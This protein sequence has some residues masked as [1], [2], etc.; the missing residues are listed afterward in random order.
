MEFQENNNAST[1]NN[2]TMGPMNTS[3]II[4]IKR[5]NV[6][7]TDIKSKRPLK[8]IPMKNIKISPY[9]TNWSNNKGQQPVN[10]PHQH[11]QQQNPVNLNQNFQMMNNSIGNGDQQSSFGNENTSNSIIGNEINLSVSDY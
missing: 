8:Q 2:S 1:L 11:L 5:N 10:I 3:E 4:M 6:I 9:N 7:K